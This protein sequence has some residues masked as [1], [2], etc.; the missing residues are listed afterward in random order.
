M[1]QTRRLVLRLIGCTLV[2]SIGGCS[3]APPEN[4]PADGTTTKPSP[5]TFPT[6]TSSNSDSLSF[7]GDVLRQASDEAPARVKAILSNRGQSSVDVG[8]GPTLLFTDNAGG[9]YDWPEDLVLKPETYI[10]P[11]DDPYQTDDGCWRFP[12]EGQTLV[13]SSLEWRTLEPN[14]SLSEEYNIYTRGDSLPCL[15]Q[16]TYRF[17]DGKFLEQEDESLIFTLALEVSDNK[18]VT[19]VSGNIT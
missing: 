10:G 19:A 2:G 14:Q 6:E 12:E 3:S 16:G 18:Q 8:Y 1:I 17:Q 11:W 7:T 9:L 13:E 4:R 15:P 5:T